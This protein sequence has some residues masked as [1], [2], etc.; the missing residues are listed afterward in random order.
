MNFAATVSATVIIP[1]LAVF[2]AW[3]ACEHFLT[4][5]N[6]ATVLH[7]VLLDAR[8]CPPFSSVVRSNADG[9]L[10]NWSLGQIIVVTPHPLYPPLSGDAKVTAV[11][12]TGAG[13]Y[14]G[15]NGF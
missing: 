1:L 6:T 12:A 4:V 7:H 13:R 3:N 15:E 2:A 8:A 5:F 11:L 14:L 10:S 9:F